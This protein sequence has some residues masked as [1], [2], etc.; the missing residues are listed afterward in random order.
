MCLNVWRN[1]SKKCLKVVWTS[2]VCFPLLWLVVL[3]QPTSCSPQ[4][5]APLTMLMRARSYGSF[6]KGSLVKKKK[7]CVW[8]G[9]LLVLV[10][11]TTAP[12]QENTDCAYMDI[13]WIYIPLNKLQA[14]WGVGVCNLVVI[15]CK[16]EIMLWDSIYIIYIKYHLLVKWRP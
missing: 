14:Y 1:A 6:P 11:M 13:W 5:V 15:L 9:P 8:H 3:E 16:I 7:W 12:L 4:T 10:A 2:E